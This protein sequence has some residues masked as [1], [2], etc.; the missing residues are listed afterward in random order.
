MYKDK[1]SGMI[2]YKTFDE[3][4]T[5][6]LLWVT[7]CDEYYYMKPPL[8]DYYDE[9]VYKVNKKTKEVSCIHYIDYMSDIESHTISI[10][11]ETLRRDYF[12]EN[13]PYIKIREPETVYI[14]LYKVDKQD[15]IAVDDSDNLDYYKHTIKSKGGTLDVEEIK[16]RYNIGEPEY[17]EDGIIINGANR[18]TLKGLLLYPYNYEVMEYGDYY[19]V[20][21][22]L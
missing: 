15:L 4:L 10:G 17:D 7:G 21:G 22:K 12:G 19:Y 13:Y 3:L 20:A 16:E 11:L 18:K 1:G 5:S 2:I 8:D 9:R 14:F 6:K